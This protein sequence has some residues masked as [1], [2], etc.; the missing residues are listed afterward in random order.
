MTALIAWLVARPRLV[1]AGAG[2]LVG[3]V[4]L[5]S[6]YVTGRGDGA[7]SAVERIERQDRRAE[8]AGEGARRD[9]RRCMETGGTWDV[10][11]GSCR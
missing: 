1:L 7:R 4:V 2:M 10:A 9:V 8:T 11:T 5:V 3:G 6:V